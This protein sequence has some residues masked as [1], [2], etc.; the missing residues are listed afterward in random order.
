MVSADRERRG[1]GAVQV[2]QSV[3]GGKKKEI[4]PSRLHR[5]P[6]K[7]TNPPSGSQKGAGAYPSSHRAGRQSIAGQTDTVT[8]TLTPLDYGRKPENPEETHAG[9]GRTF[10][11]H[12]ERTPVTWQGNR[13]QALL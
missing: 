8:H 4:T 6:K 12:T 5:R 3:M 7:P 1:V 9:T 2:S 13:T 10:R 11:L